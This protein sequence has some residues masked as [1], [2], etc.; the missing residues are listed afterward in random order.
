MS[1]RLF[2]LMEENKTTQL[3]LSSATGISQGNISD[4]K[5]GRSTPKIDALTKLADYFHVST[6]YLLGR[7]DKRTAGPSEEEPAALLQKPYMKEILEALD[8][9]TPESLELVLAQ[10]RAVAN[11]Q[12]NAKK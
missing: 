11:L 12:S 7:T 10:V 2:A 9:L 3:Q 4:W 8:R 6:D 1:L 5:N